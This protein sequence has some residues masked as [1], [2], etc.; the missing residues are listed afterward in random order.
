MKCYYPSL[1]MEYPNIYMV[2]TN[3]FAFSL[4]F[5]NTW[6]GCALAIPQVNRIFI[7]LSNGLLHVLY[8]NTTLPTTQ[9]WYTQAPAPGGGPASCS[10]IVPAPAGY[11]NGV[12]CPTGLASACTSVACASGYYGMAQVVCVLNGS[13]FTYEGCS[14]CS[15]CGGSTWQSSACSAT[16]NTVCANCST[17]TGNTY[18]ASGCS[19]TSNTACANCSTC[20]GNTYQASG[21]SATSN[22]ACANCSTCTGNMYQTSACSATTNTACATCSS[23]SKVDPQTGACVENAAAR[24]STHQMVWAALLVAVAAA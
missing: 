13:S 8:M 14:A 17:C 10:P 23:G 7:S 20:T 6:N 2:C 22:T 18:Q 1:A 16:A 3:Y 4:D 19:A 9:I 24:L 11:S 15:V 5:G 21:C 12:S